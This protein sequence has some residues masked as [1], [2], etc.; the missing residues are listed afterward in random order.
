MAWLQNKRL[1]VIQAW[2]ALERQYLLPNTPQWGEQM[3]TAIQRIADG[4]M[5]AVT[6]AC[7]TR[8]LVPNLTLPSGRAAEIKTR[9]MRKAKAF[10]SLL[11]RHKF[12]I[13]VL[14]QFMKWSA[15]YYVH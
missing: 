10:L 5:D 7:T 1:F 14:H 15:Q 6:M 9:A 11:S 8:S 4:V 12:A 13:R 3:R 2:D